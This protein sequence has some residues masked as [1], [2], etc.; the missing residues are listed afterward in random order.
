MDYWVFIFAS[1]RNIELAPLKTW[2]ELLKFSDVVKGKVVEMPPNLPMEAFPRAIPG[3]N[4][5][6]IRFRCEDPSDKP[7]TAWT[8]ALLPW[9]L[10]SSNDGAGSALNEFAHHA[11]NDEILAGFRVWLV[12]NRNLLFEP[13]D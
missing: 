4:T 6:M 12:E 8:S 10:L 2:R 13:M 3:F 9:L 11:A 5:M 1:E 7:W